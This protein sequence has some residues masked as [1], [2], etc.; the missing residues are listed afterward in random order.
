MKCKA[1]GMCLVNCYFPPHGTK[2]YQEITNAILARLDDVLNQLPARCTPLIF[3]DN[4][5][6]V[7]YYNQPGDADDEFDG[8]IGKCQQGKFGFNGLGMA[9][10][11]KPHAL[12]FVNSVSL[13]V[14]R[15]TSWTKA[16]QAGLIMC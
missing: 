5:S 6:D 15:S 2:R 1:L 14:V 3:T 9:R 13:Q 16:P 11:A 8:I 7:G 4:N 12:C 10:I